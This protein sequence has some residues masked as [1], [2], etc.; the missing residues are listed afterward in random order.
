MRTYFARYQEEKLINA[1]AQDVFSYVDDHNRFSSHMS[2][3]SWRMGGGSMQVTVDE[4]RGQKV[5]SH[6][7]LQGKAFGIVI[8]LDEVVTQYEPPFVKTWETVSEPKLI[9]VGQYQMGVEIQP[10][11]ESSL[12]N[13]FVEYD[14]PKTQVWLGKL[15]GRMYAKWC[16]RQMLKNTYTYFQSL[17]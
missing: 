8:N 2:Q 7:H 4:G 16:V 11:G 15:F 13:V 6:I 5:D 14:P 9:V 12:L 17:S 3:P 10:K 1:T